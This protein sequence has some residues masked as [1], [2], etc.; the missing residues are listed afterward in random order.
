MSGPYSQG[1][2]AGVATRG[3]IYIDSGDSTLG[4]V[5]VIPIGLTEV[6]S[7]ESWVKAGDMVKKGA[8]LGQFS[9]GGSSFAIAFQPGAIKEILV[10]PPLTGRNDQPVDTLKANQACAIANLAGDSEYFKPEP[11]KS[12]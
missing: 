9:F 6:S 11:K 5:C 1:W 3:L 12:E 10:K 8:V 2:A 7:L 4:T